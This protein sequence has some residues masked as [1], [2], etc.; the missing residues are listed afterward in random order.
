MARIPR[1]I[2]VEGNDNLVRDMKSKAILNT[3]VEALKA[4]KKQREEANK[5]HNMLE[6]FP[7][8]KRDVSEI[9]GM[10]LSLLDKLG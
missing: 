7:G 6:E 3:N 2:K 10:L 1:F 8:L 4:H 9:R 5:V